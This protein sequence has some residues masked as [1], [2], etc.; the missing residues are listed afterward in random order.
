MEDSSSENIISDSPVNRA[1]MDKNLDS[2]D[3][4]NVIFMGKNDGVNGSKDGMKLDNYLGEYDLSGRVDCNIGKGSVYRDILE[5][6]TPYI[7]NEVINKE[8]GPAEID[9][10][11]LFQSSSE[12]LL[13]EENKEQK[14]GRLGLKNY[15]DSSLVEADI[16]SSIIVASQDVDLLSGKSFGD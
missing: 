12:E 7:G 5:C 4:I 3:A 9:G 6:F 11:V 1:T 15:L 8:V 2:A 13:C 16:L 14:I 10:N